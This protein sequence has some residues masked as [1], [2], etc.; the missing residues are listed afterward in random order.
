MEMVFVE[1]RDHSIRAGKGDKG[2]IMSPT[3]SIMDQGKKES[4]LY[5]SCNSPLFKIISK[6]PYY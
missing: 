2:V 3:D 6:Y 4:F 5:Y 1:N